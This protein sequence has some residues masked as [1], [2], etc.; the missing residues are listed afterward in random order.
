[1]KITKLNLQNAL[2]ISTHVTDDGVM[3]DVYDKEFNKITIDYLDY[4]NLKVV[5]SSCVDYHSNT[6]KPNEEGKVKVKYRMR[7]EMV[8]IEEIDLIDL[9]PD[10]R[11]S[12]T[13]RRIPFVNFTDS[14]RISM[15]TSMLKQS[16]VVNNAQRPLV[17]TG[18]YE[19][20]K[21][22]VM[23]ERFEVDSDD[24]GIVKEISPDYVVIKGKKS[25]KLIHFNRRTAV[26]SINDVTMYTEPKVRVGDTVKR[27]DIICGPVE[28][29]K[30]TVKVGCNANVLYHAYHGLVNED[31]VVIS[32]SYADRMSAYQLI[33]LQFDVKNNAKIK[34]IAP[35]GTQ[36]KSKDSIVTLTRLSKFDEITR[37]ALSKLGGLIDDGSLQEFESEFNYKIENNIEDAVISDIIIQR[38]N[39]E[40]KAAADKKKGKNIKFDYALLSQRYI[41]EYMAEKPKARQVIY[42]RYPEYVASDTLKPV[43]LDTKGFKV[44][45]TIRVRLIKYS[46]CVKGEKITNRFGG[47]GV[48][49]AIIPDDQMP[50]VA[51]KRIEV[52]LNPLIEVAIY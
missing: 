14:V 19:E 1:M 7:T 48:V 50:I 39:C 4:L 25:G 36:V 31:A 3:F 35:I 18:H 8:P 17:D 9:H 27:G 52:V 15:G 32:E 29:A 21:N 10:Y 28:L 42:D 26:H 2:T 30:D 22:N 37:N 5:D 13:T 34:W 44:V 49:S 33:D 47:K 41:D 38:N 43:S 6:L 45:Y 12:E 40:E 11:L 23:N 51:G 24:E 46:K 20:L 16:M